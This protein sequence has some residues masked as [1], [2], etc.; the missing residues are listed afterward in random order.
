M[1]ED[2][3]APRE[4][5][6]G[7]VASD[8]SGVL[9]PTDTVDK[10]HAEVQDV[11]EN[12]SLSAMADNGTL[13]QG[14]SPD[15]SRYETPRIRDAAQQFLEML[16]ADKGG[17]G[18]RPEEELRRIMAIPI[19]MRAIMVH[20]IA[21]IHQGDYTVQQYLDWYNSKP[22]SDTDFE[23][24]LAQWKQEFPMARTTRERIETWKE[25][26]TRASKKQ[27]RDLLNGA[28]KAFLQQE[29]MNTQLAL[30]LLKH[31]TAMVNTLLEAW[32]QYLASEQ[33]LKEKARAQKLDENNTETVNEKR[34]QLE[35]KTRVHRL[36]Y[37]VRQ[38][39]ALHRNSKAISDKDRELY[40][41][42][43]SGNLSKELD[44]CTRAHGYGKLPS[45]GAMLEN[46]G[47]RGP[48]KH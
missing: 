7:Y 10:V 13:R 19:R 29:C 47:F 25:E 32:A 23:W 39:K 4:R 41:A 48:R 35:L 45:T 18:V 34:R 26:D 40:E 27:A 30:A 33:Y 20:R 46:L 9:Q 44:E 15:A 3:S 38:A 12:I 11:I 16:Y 31:P 36:R 14:D 43:L 37:Q 1:I 17:Y 42:W 8:T 28:F 24:A 21:H 6:A 5:L 2:A 22:L